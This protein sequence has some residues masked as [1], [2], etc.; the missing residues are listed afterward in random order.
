MMKHYRTTLTLL[1]LFFVSL[2]TLVGLERAG[3]LTEREKSGAT[4][5]FCP[6]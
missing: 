6:S 1:L 5:A 3:I 2:L 4:L